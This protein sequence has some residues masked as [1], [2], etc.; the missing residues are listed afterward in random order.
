M[1]HGGLGNNWMP[2]DKATNTLSKAIRFVFISTMLIG[3]I[4]HPYN[5]CAGYGNLS[6]HVSVLE[7]I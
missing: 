7:G 5:P 3:W 1:F 4:I 6:I 2:M